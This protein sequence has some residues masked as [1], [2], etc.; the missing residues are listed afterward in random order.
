GTEQLAKTTH[1]GS[2]LGGRFVTFNET[3]NTGYLPVKFYYNPSDAPTGNSTV[4]ATINEAFNVWNNLSFCSLKF[5]AMSSSDLTNEGQVN[6]STSVILWRDHY[7]ANVYAREYPYPTQAGPGTKVGSD[8]AFNYNIGDYQWYFESS[9]LTSRLGY[10]IDFADVLVHELGH[11]QG[12]D[13]SGFNTVIMYGGSWQGIQVF[14][15]RTLADGDKAGGVY[16]HT[17]SPISLS[18]AIPQ[19]L[20]LSALPNRI[21]NL[22]GNVTIPSGKTF[23]LESSIAQVNLNGYSMKSTGGSFIDAGGNTWQ[24]ADICRKAGSTLLA[25]YSTLLSAIQE[26]TS[27]QTVIVNGGTHSYGSNLIVAAGVTLQLNAGTT[28]TFTGPY[29]LTVN[30]GLV[31]YGTSSQP[32]TFTRNGGTWYGIEAN[33]GSI[34]LRYCSV[35]NAQN[36]V[37]AYRSAGYL[38]HVTITGSATGMRYDNQSWGDVRYSSITSCTYGI[39]CSQNSNPSIRPYNRIWNHTT[40]VYSDYN[41][42]P[43]LGTLSGWGNNSIKNNA[44]MDVWSE[45]SNTVYAQYNY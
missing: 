26:A 12:L 17:V 19:S 42:L 34:D 16:Q 31:A 25:H 24:P 7:N 2:H 22:T 14:P 6:N 23:E 8:I 28:L 29:K 41:S 15:L 36:G 44:T 13:H 35:Q 45:N 1:V 11:T 3:W 32:I 21:V 5:A 20:V 18:G 33:Y 30:G 37:K 40:G 27:G 43:V 4:I 38:D 9:P 10:Q 39:H